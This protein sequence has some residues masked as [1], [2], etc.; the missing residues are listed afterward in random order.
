MT[1]ISEATAFEMIRRLVQGAADYQADL[2]VTLCP[3][4]QLNLDA[5]QGEMNKHFKTNYHM[6]VLYFTQLMGLAFGIDAQD[7]GH[8]QRTGR[9]RAGAGQDR[10]RGARRRARQA[11]EAKPGRQVAAHAAA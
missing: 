11:E 9:R 5:F 10:C 3:M 7:P 8:R 1:Q 6:P 2:I 4:C